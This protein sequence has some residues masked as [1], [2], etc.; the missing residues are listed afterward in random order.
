MS[1]CLDDHQRHHP[2]H[3][4]LNLM[5]LLRRAPLTAPTHDPKS[6]LLIDMAYT[7]RRAGERLRFIAKMNCW[8]R[9]QADGKA[10]DTGA[11]GRCHLLELPTELVL[12]IISHL[13]VLPEACLALTCR[14]L[15]SICAPILEAK[16]LHFSRD[17]APL[18]HH[19]RNGHNF[20]TPRWQFINL[21]ED[22]RWKA[23]SKCLK[24]HPR[25]SFPPRELRRKAEDR[26]CNLGSSAGIVDLCPCKKLTFQDKMELADLLKVRRKSVAALT[27]QFGEGVKKQRF[28]WHTCTEDYGST[29]LKIEIY[30]EL[31]EE[32]QLKIKTEYHLSTGSGQLGREEHMTPR[33]GCAHRS[34]DLWL[35]S[36]CQTTICRLYDNH[37]ASCKRISICNTCNATLKCPRK[38]PCRLDEAT[39]QATYQFWTER[40]LGGSGP[41]PDQAWAVQRIHPAENLIDVANCSELCPWTIREHPPPEEPPTLG[42]GILDPAMQDQSMNQLPQ[43]IHEHCLRPG[44][45]S[46]P[47]P[48]NGQYP[49]QY[50]QQPPNLPLHQQ[51]IHPQQLLY[52]SN[53]DPSGSPYQYGKPVVYPQVMIPTYPAYSQSYTPQQQQQPQPQ[54]PPQQQQQQQQ[55]PPPPQQLPQQQYVNP[56]DLFQPPPLPSTSPPQ[57]TTNSP[58]QYAA[59]PAISVAGNSRSPVLPPSTPAPST[60]Y[61]APSPNQG[62]Q[63]YSQP[64]PPTPTVQISSVTPTVTP[65]VTPKPVAAKPVAAKPP[66][67]K[68]VAPKPATPKPVTP[69]P[70]AAKPVASKPVVSKQVAAKPVAAKP[71]A[72]K[73]VV[74]TPPAPSPKPVQVLIPAPTPEVQQKLQQ[75]QSSKKQGPRQ[76]G[77]HPPQKPAKS[78]IDYQVLLLAMADEYLNAAHSHGTMVALLRREMEMDEYYKLVATGLG[79]LEAVLKNWRL[80]PRV[81]ALV[82]LRYAR[83]LFEETDNNLEAE[84]ALSK[85]IDL[86]ERNRMLDLKYS[87]QHLLARMLHKTN[88]KASLKNVDKTIQEVEAYRH[89]AWEYAF[90]FL[91]VSL[92]LSSS[93]HQ[94]SVSALQHLHKISNMASRNGD[95]AV[96]AMSAIIEALAHLQQGSGFDSIEQAQRA[97]AVARSHQLNDEL[98]HIPQLTTLVQIVDICCS[99]LDYDINQSSQKLKVMQDLM[100]ERLNDSNWRSDGSFSIP[101]NGKSAGPSS[102]DTGDILQVQSGTLLLSFNWLPQHDLYALCYFLS[103]ITL[104]CKNSYD[105]RKAEKFLQEGTRMLKGSFKA[106]QEITESVVN[107]NRRVEWRRTLYC[108][109]LIQQVFLSCG[110]T[111]WDLAIKT[112]N[113]LHQEAQELGDNLSDTIRCL[114]EYAAGAIA[115]ATGD[116]NAAL[117]SFRSPLLSLST[118]FSKTAR[119][120][121]RRDISILAALNTV[122]ILRDPTHPSHSDLPSLLNSVDSFCTGSPNKYIQAAYYL[123]CATV[124]TES[125]IQTKQ[126]LQQ[127]L[128]SATAI[129]NSQITCM[130]L[131]FM[132]WKYFRGVVGEQAEKSAR[133]G[134]AMAKKANDRLWVSV[135]DEMLAETLERQGKNDEAQ[136]VREEGH[137][138]MMGLPPPL[139]RPV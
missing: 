80:Q 68:P 35:A 55:Q 3:L 10:A 39:G 57:F 109:F 43:W 48:H 132:S 86:C 117:N 59:Q 77:Q 106:P 111:D 82:R 137:R 56:S 114:M 139:K 131:T 128:Q 17:F 16:P 21:L 105:G 73:P 9:N 118:T 41:V 30:P 5:K 20:V 51:T 112:L 102:I 42:M 38:Q 78:P 110:R 29:Q 85:G 4:H 2:N 130:T 88:P 25:N 66:A 87:M 91:R 75:R 94:D 126:Y 45:M 13:S 101:L 76:N 84:T 97:V 99:L 103:S 67:A 129:S 36:V 83:I 92:S 69:K 18:F 104:S 26:S 62:N 61:A 134:R 63:A 65:A 119:N 100:D 135:T 133:A 14:R 121:P 1:F 33:F 19:Y 125:T 58:S 122:L 53:V 7:F 11:L 107:A 31:D 120:D 52:N 123:V 124:Q 71:I 24:L 95:K 108:N 72:V 28:C 116:L 93:A 32:D 12:E 44:A 89:S 136:G 23:C 37:C 49:P 8:A 113:E 6:D 22:G 138:V 74:A 81:E 50:M 15:Y 27:V 47:P 115:Q 70:V 54:P 34:I 90:R 64:T 127:A 96:S 46:Y 98:R 60:Y 40:C 79:C